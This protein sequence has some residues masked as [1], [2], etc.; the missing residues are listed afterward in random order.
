ME[1]PELVEI[2]RPVRRVPAWPVL[3]GV[4]LALA[5]VGG[6]LALARGNCDRAFVVPMRGDMQAVVVVLRSP[7]EISAATLVLAG[8]GEVECST[9]LPGRVEALIFFAGAAEHPERVEAVTAS[10]RRMVI[11]VGR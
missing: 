10:G 7:E 8:G 6:I 3:V 11:P 9:P 4:G 5:V 1:E 2:K